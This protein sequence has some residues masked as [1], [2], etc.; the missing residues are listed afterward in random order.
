[1]K[2]EFFQQDDITIRFWFS[3]SSDANWCLTDSQHLK[4]FFAHEK[5]EKPSWKVAKKYR[6]KKGNSGI[7]QNVAYRP[8]VNQIGVGVMVCKSWQSAR[9]ECKTN[10]DSMHFPTC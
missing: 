8:T 9:I 3:P 1:M 2:N 6:P 5:L 7:S 10:I 4:C